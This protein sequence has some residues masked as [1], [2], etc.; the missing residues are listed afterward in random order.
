MI[1]QNDSDLIQDY[2]N[3]QTK[4][5]AKKLCGQRSEKTQRGEKQ[6]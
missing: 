3:K 6:K 4:R 5:Q 2:L 1:K